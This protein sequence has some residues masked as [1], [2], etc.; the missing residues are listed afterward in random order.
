M[1]KPIYV[2]APQSQQKAP[3][4]PAFPS[5]PVPIDPALLSQVAGGTDTTSAPGRGW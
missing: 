1:Q 4:A 5:A 3:V 2:A